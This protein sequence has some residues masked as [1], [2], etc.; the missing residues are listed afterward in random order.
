[1]MTVKSAALFRKYHR[2]LGFFL[3]GVMLIY[4]SS[5]V[6]LIF[7][8]TDFL[9]YEQTV[10][11]ALAAD[12]TASELGRQLRLKDFAVTGEADGTLFFEQ[13]SYSKSDGIAT[14][15]LTDYPAPV[16][17][18]VQLHKATPESPLFF[19]NVFFGLGLLF[20][21]LS[22]FFMF[23]RQAPAYKSGLKFAL[24][25]AVVALAMVFMG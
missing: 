24:A 11:R 20:L 19:M 2:L 17:K 1:M 15:T 3:A 6:L 4:A 22:S 9:K 23:L 10:T 12:L 18:L 7:R 25:G 16:K 14:L 5:G 8:T 13:G 21:A